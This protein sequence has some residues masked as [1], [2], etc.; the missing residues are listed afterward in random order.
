VLVKKCRRALQDGIVKVV[1]QIRN[2]AEPGIVHQVRA[3]IITDPFQYG[4]RNQ[5]KCHDRPRI[6]KVRRNKLLQ[7]NRMPAARNRKQL[8]LA[9]LRTR[10]QHPIKDRP[11]QQQPERIKQ[12]HRGHQEYRSPDRPPVGRNI[13]YK[14]RQ[15]PHRRLPVRNETRPATDEIGMRRKPLFYTLSPRA[16]SVPCHPERILYLSSR[17]NSVPVIPSE[18]CTC[19]PERRL[20]VR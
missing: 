13:T 4:G 12:S 5:G 17:A 19:H 18:F 20:I 1:A 3:R 11:D 14:A 10:I 9:R 8:H 2:H 16:K 7:I 15:L 6:L